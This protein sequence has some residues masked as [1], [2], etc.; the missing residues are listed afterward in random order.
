[1]RG[2]RQSFILWRFVLHNVL[3]VLVENILFRMY[4][5]NYYDGPIT[6]NE[7]LKLF[8]SY[9]DIRYVLLLTH[10]G[11]FSS[12]TFILWSFVPFFLDGLS[13]FFAWLSFCGKKWSCIFIF[14]FSKFARIFCNRPCWLNQS[15]FMKGGMFHKQKYNVASAGPYFDNMYFSE[16]LESILFFKLNFYL[17]FCP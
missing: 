12:L 13:Q 10:K 14:Y 9:S 1:M 16:W 11:T 4:K 15:W 8:F 2:N 7:L 3:I 6:S 17:P 5:L